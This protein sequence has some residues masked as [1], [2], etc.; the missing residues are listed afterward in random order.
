[1][2]LSMRLFRL[3]YLSIP[4]P[5]YDAFFDRPKTWRKPEVEKHSQKHD[6][7][8]QKNNTKARKFD[9]KSVSFRNLWISTKTGAAHKKQHLIGAPGVSI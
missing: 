6:T 9:T 3:F 1:M 2:Y 5:P 4:G 8:A 7:K